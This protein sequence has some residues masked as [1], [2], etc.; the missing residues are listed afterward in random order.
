MRAAWTLPHSVSL[1]IL[2]NLLFY[3]ST[4]S[5]HLSPLFLSIFYL[6]TCVQVS[7][8]LLLCMRA[9]WTL[10][11]SISFTLFCLTFYSISQYS[12]ILSPSH[13]ICFL[14]CY[15]CASLRCAVAVYESW[16]HFAALCFIS[17]QVP[18]FVGVSVP[19]YYWGCHFIHM[20]RDVLFNLHRIC[21]QNVIILE[22]PQKVNVSS[23][24]IQNLQQ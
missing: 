17:G 9:D 7:Y 11:N 13:S 6:V 14:F 1:I 4:L 3:P 18:H 19:T 8:V 16:L 23:D 21:I 20:I 22:S 2:S 15:L 24:E 12:S 5:W 10:P